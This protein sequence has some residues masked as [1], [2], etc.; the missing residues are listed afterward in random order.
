[1]SGREESRCMV[2]HKLRGIETLFSASECCGLIIPG[3]VQ[4]SDPR[5]EGVESVDNIM[6]KEFAN[7]SP[8]Q[9]MFATWSKDVKAI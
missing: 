6:F 7:R 5:S 4:V 9:E 2:C 3:L 1:M 8:K